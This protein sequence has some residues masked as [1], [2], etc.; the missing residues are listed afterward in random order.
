MSGLHSRTFHLPMVKDLLSLSVALT[1]SIPEGTCMMST[2]SHSRTWTIHTEMY[3]LLSDTS[4]STVYWSYL[5][6]M[7]VTISPKLL[8]MSQYL[9]QH[10]I[11]HFGQV[12]RV[13]ES[14]RLMSAGIHF[15]TDV[16]TQDYNTSFTS[17][18][19]HWHNN[20]RQFLQINNSKVALWNNVKSLRIMTQNK[21][22]TNSWAGGILLSTVLVD[23]L[24]S[25]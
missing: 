10:Y 3:V 6:S 19:L 20:H 18:S 7:L 22:K 2:Q 21:H 23:T 13:M 11:S 16:V 1:C 5:W 9:E 25:V 12:Y 24:F 14:A 15:H 8:F 4:P 17:L